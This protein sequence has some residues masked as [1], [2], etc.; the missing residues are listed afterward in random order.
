MWPSQAERSV[1][2]RPRWCERQTNPSRLSIQLRFP[3]FSCSASS[4]ALSPVLD[5]LLAASPPV[6]PPAEHGTDDPVRTPNVDSLT[7]A[8]F[9]AHAIQYCAEASEAARHREAAA[10]PLEAA[11]VAAQRLAAETKDALVALEKPRREVEQEAAALKLQAEAVLKLQ[12]EAESRR[13]ALEEKAQ[14]LQVEMANNERKAAAAKLA[15]ALHQQRGADGGTT[16]DSAAAVVLGSSKVAPFKK[17]E[18]DYMQG[19]SVG[20]LLEVLEA[21]LFCRPPSSF[22]LLRSSHLLL[23]AHAC[24]TVP[25]VC[26]PLRV[27]FG[28]VQPYYVRDFLLRPRC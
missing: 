12:A 14:R 6:A 21:R 4:T 8:H 18:F 26:E 2:V 17:W 1:R 24:I 23:L 9:A 19:M 10:V 25:S 11:S 28:C 3:A 22:L 13:D 7:L 15:A 20:T 16:A 5:D 27:Q